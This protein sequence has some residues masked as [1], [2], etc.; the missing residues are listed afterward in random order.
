MFPLLHSSVFSKSCLAVSKL[1]SF[2]F[3]VAPSLHVVLASKATPISSFLSLSDRRREGGGELIESSVG[4]KSFAL[5]PLLGSFAKQLPLGL[6]PN[7]P[8]IRLQASFHPYLSWVWGEACLGLHC[9][10]KPPADVF[11]L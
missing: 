6:P 5:V 4:F 8:G 11:F 1:F 9:P 7:A 10:R 2:Y 3:S